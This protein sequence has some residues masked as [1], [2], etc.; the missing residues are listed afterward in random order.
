MEDEEGEQF[1]NTYLDEMLSGRPA[2]NSSHNINYA[3]A[4]HHGAPDGIQGRES[5]AVPLSELKFRN[6]LL[7]SHLRSSYAIQYTDQ[8]STED[9]IKVSYMKTPTKLERTFTV[10][11]PHM[12]HYRSSPDL[13]R[14]GLRFDEESQL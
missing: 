14:S 11:R 10:S 7:P 8:F 1:C 12:L 6:S 13:R 9:D 3:G 4:S 5:S 2:S